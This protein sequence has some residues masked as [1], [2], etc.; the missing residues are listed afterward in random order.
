MLVLCRIH[1]YSGQIN[2]LPME[3][4]KKSIFRDQKPEE[5][6]TNKLISSRTTGN[7]DGPQET[8]ETIIIEE[9]HIL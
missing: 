1:V 9:D 7:E 8:C 6:E 3:T 2:N 5:K 4:K